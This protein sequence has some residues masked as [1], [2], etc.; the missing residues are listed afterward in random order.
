MQRFLFPHTTVGTRA[1]SVMP[2]S[3]SSDPAT[4][5]GAEKKL[6]VKETEPPE[7]IY[8]KVYKSQISASSRQSRRRANARHGQIARLLSGDDLR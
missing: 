2:I 5:A 7:L 6:T 3:D 4:K 1:R 8:F